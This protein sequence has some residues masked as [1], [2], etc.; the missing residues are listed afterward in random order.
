M[1]YTTAKLITTRHK[2]VILNQCGLFQTDFFNAYWCFIDAL[3]NMETWKWKQEQVTQYAQTQRTCSRCC[4]KR[5]FIEGLE[6]STLIRQ[7]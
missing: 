1:S 6:S 2:V 7:K 4:N 5:Q 3:S